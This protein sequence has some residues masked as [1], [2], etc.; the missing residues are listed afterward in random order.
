MEKALKDK[1]QTNLI[2]CIDFK[3]FEQFNINE[4]GPLELTVKINDEDTTF[5]IKYPLEIVNKQDSKITRLLDFKK[6]IQTKLG[7]LSDL[8]RDI[9]N[10][11]NFGVM[12][13]Y[14]SYDPSNE[15]TEAQRNIN[16]LEELTLDI[17]RSNSNVIFPYEGMEFTTDKR[18]WS[19][20]NDL[21]PE[22]SKALW[23]NLDCIT[24]RGT[25]SEKLPASCLPEEYSAYYQKFSIPVTSDPKYKNTIVR[26]TLKYENDVV[27]FT[28]FSV[29]PS[30]GDIVKPID[31]FNSRNPITNIKR[32]WLI[33]HLNFRF[34]FGNNYT[35]LI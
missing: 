6:I 19:I 7:K 17:L 33:Y 25:A 10:K 14:D 24:Y 4:K 8:A 30:K 22:L 29:S 13:T 2:K 31:I 27:D 3:Q 1:I 26:T 23:E 16:F 15:Q 18:Q 20:E 21:K 5:S 32:L 9:M 11:E 12:T 35:S 28:E 34:P